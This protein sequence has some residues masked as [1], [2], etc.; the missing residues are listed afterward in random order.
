M[1]RPS[2]LAHHPAQGHLRVSGLES[3]LHRGPNPILRLGVAHAL[4]EEIG[5]AAE[6]LGP[7]KRYGIDAGFER[8]RAGGRKAGDS[9][10]QRSDEIAE[11]P[12]PAMPG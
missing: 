4:T 7:R 11:R 2:P 9:M 10:R 5:I 6:V 3:A 8:E 12:G 1:S